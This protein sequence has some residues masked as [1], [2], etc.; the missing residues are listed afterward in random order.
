MSDEKI[1]LQLRDLDEMLKKV[2]N[3]FVI[4]CGGFS[5]FCFALAKFAV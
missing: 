2:R 5:L 1:A 4:Y 3:V